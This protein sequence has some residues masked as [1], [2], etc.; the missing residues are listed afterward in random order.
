MGKSI[1]KGMSGHHSTKMI[2]DEWLTPKYIT[3]SLGEFDLDPCS[4]INRPWNTAKKHYTIEDDGLSKEWFGRVWCNPPYGNTATKWLRKMAFHRNGIVLIF[5]RTETKMF[6]KYVW[7]R[8]DSVLFIAGRVTFHKV[9]GS[10]PKNNA[11]APS[12]LIA[13]GDDNS[14]ILENSGI[15]GKFIKLT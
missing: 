13:Y 4:P 15:V 1:E 8:A 7:G 2:T 6:F 11:G 10:V 5:A 12:V 9:D 14:E 3:D